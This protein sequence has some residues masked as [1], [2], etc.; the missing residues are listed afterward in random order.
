ME[1]TTNSFNISKSL[2][3]KELSEIERIKTDISKIPNFPSEGILFYDI[4]SLLCNPELTEI[5]FRVSEKIICE[6]QK[7]PEQSFNTI[8]GLESRGF[9]LGMV[10]A[11]RLKLPFVPV[12]KKNKLPGDC[13]KIHYTTEYSN[14]TFEIQKNAINAESKILIID[15]LLAT[16]G[17][18]KAAEDLA[19]LAGA[20]VSGFF[21][22]FE[23]EFLKGKEKLEN[24]AKSFSLVQI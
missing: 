17:T 15:D 23:I 16:G 2:S 10:L 13:Y 1:N 21:T 3:E 4:F 20:Q 11:D 12:R 5:L 6:I 22:V 14:D 19:K 9:L 7:Q 18:L 24:K 8:L